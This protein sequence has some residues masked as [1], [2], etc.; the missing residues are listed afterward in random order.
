MEVTG[1]SLDDRDTSLDEAENNLHL[2]PDQETGLI[3]LHQAAL[4]LLNQ[5]SIAYRVNQLV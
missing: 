4:Y 5:V 3:P 1:G 2:E